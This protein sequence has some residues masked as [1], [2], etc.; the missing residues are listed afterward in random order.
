MIKLHKPTRLPMFIHPATLVSD[1]MRQAR[2]SGEKIILSADG[3]NFGKTGR[4]RKGKKEEQRY[5]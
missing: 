2:N 5:V 4:K 1:L 3:W